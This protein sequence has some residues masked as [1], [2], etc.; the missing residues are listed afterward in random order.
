MMLWW[1]LVKF[2]FRLL[3][4]ELAFTYDWVSTLVSLGQWR[5]WQRAGLKQLGVKPGTWV[6]EIAHGTGDSQLD[7][8]D[9]GYRTLGCDLSPQMGRI[10][11]RKLQHHGKVARLTRS[12]AQQLPFANNTF[13][14][15]ICTFPTPFVFERETLREAHRVLKPGGRFVVVLN[16]VLTGKGLLT[17]LLE[18][19]Y[20]ITGQRPPEYQAK[21]HRAPDSP[22]MQQ[23]IQRFEAAGFSAV[24][25]QESCGDSYAQLIAAT[26]INVA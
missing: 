21:D 4:N 23:I 26:T 19:L 1:R 12:K 11:R 8:L 7:L 22:M 10:A 5:S 15:V 9:A 6:L 13:D 3:Y 25:I 17:R 14:A 16:G 20:R 24:W 18:A 2:G